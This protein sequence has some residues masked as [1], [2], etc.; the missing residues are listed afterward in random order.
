[1]LQVGSLFLRSCLC[2]VRCL[3]MLPGSSW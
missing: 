1:L 2:R 3:S